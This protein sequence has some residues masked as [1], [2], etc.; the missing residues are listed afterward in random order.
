MEQRIRRGLPAFAAEELASRGIVTREPLQED[1]VNAG[2]FDGQNL[3]IM[4]PTSSGKTLKSELS[5]AYH[6]THRSGSVM[7]T[8]LK[9]LASEKYLTFRESY[10]RPDRFHFHTS[11][12]TGDK[13]TDQRQ[14]HVVHLCARARS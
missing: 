1:A 7:V 6:A 5:G 12:A 9:A 3:A 13:V 11:I 4:A 8:S 2:L 14:R 10:S